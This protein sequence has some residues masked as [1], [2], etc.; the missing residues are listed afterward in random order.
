MKEFAEK[1]GFFG[2]A[3]TSAKSGQGI[4]NEFEEL[5]KRIK[6]NE[7]N[8]QTKVLLSLFLGCILLNLIVFGMHSFESHCF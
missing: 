7:E 1:E 2:W 5:A 4:E 6:H 3:F 8:I